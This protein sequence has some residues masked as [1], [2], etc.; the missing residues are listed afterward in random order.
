MLL[1]ATLSSTT[2][3]AKNYL[4]RKTGFFFST[5][6][7]F[8]IKSAALRMRTIILNN[9]CA[10]KCFL[11]ITLY[12]KEC[13][14]KQN[15]G[16]GQSLKFSYNFK[17]EVLNIFCYYLIRI[18]ILNTYTFYKCCLKLLSYIENWVKNKMWSLGIS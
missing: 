6:I 8:Y 10:H 5:Y 4:L 7:S 16:Y 17:I 14:P 3:I 9:F 15:F 2:Y 13:G 11:T 18:T 1:K 12:V